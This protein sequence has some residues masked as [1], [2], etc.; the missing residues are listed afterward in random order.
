MRI[1]V[2]VAMTDVMDNDGRLMDRGRAD[3]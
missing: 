2:K 3:A 1:L